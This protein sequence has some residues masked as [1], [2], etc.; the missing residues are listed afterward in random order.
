MRTVTVSQI[1]TEID[2][3]TEALLFGAIQELEHLCDSL[4]RCRVEVIGG[5][6]PSGEHKPW[7]VKLLLC[8]CEHDIFSEGL[9]DSRAAEPRKAILIAIREAKL[10]L[11]DMKTS[12]E[13]T[14]CCDQL[15]HPS[16]AAVESHNSA[17]G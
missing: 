13:C 6:S 10:Q 2:D 17:S 7:R 4:L 3:A 11:L 9:D 5:I 8:T 12:R 15:S 16:S 1:E 14:A